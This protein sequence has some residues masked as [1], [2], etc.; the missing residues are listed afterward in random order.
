MKTPMSAV[1]PRFIF[2]VLSIAFWLM[3]PYPVFGA[4][5]PRETAGSPRGF[6]AAPQ[7]LPY[8]DVL[9]RGVEAINLRRS[10]GVGR[11]EGTLPSVACWCLAMAAIA[12]AGLPMMA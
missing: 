8:G 10:R 12:V 5:G 9:V 11:P 7:G 2:A 4:E 1:R 6:T 3:C